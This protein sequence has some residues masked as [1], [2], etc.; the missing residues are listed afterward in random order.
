MNDILHPMSVKQNNQ[1]DRRTMLQ[2]ERK[3]EMQEFMAKQANIVNPRLRKIFKERNGGND[4]QP[5]NTYVPMLTN[6]K[7]NRQP[8]N[9]SP[10]TK[11]SRPTHNYSHEMNDTYQPP[12]HPQ[13]H[14]Q[15]PYFYPNQPLMYGDPR[16]S[17]PYFQPHQPYGVGGLPYP[18]MPNP[19]NNISQNGYP[20]MKPYDSRDLPQSSYGGSPIERNHIP[21]HHTRFEDNNNRPERYQNEQ[22]FGI[23]ERRHQPPE[24]NRRIPSKSEYAAA[25]EKQIAEKEAKKRLDR[26]LKQQTEPGM[27]FST[28]S[29]RSDKVSNVQPNTHHH[30]HSELTDRYSSRN[31]Q[32]QS[33]YLKE[34]D[35]QI[36]IKKEIRQKESYDYNHPPNSQSHEYP[37]STSPFSLPDIHH[38]RKQFPNE[39]AKIL[40]SDVFPQS[41]ST[42]T[43]QNHYSTLPPIQAQS[44]ISQSKYKGGDYQNFGEESFPPNQG[45]EIPTNFLRGAMQVKDMPQWQRE[46]MVI[47][48]QLKQKNQREVQNVLRQQIAEKEMLKQKQIEQQRKEDEIE[49]VRIEREQAL[50]KEKYRK[51]REEALKKEEEERKEKERLKKIK[52]QEEEKQTQNTHKVQTKRTKLSKPAISRTQSPVPIQTVSIPFRSDSPPIPTLLKKMKQDQ[53][54]NPIVEEQSKVEETIVPQIQPNVNNNTNSYISTT[55]RTETPQNINHGD[56]NFSKSAGNELL[57]QLEAIQRVNHKY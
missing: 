16:V 47:K 3:R 49:R 57:Q 38:T 50:L 34:L 22:N 33:Q 44:N 54:S 20:P 45:V 31:Q 21:Q 19:Y 15:Q 55:I 5:S 53:I 30:H 51:E 18:M 42:P 27:F 1:Q 7:S 24:S 39:R 46:E 40:H 43:F 8:D 23:G 32:S 2:Q 56:N 28:S 11:S 37:P 25:L 4:N 6:T 9:Y 36:R 52:E 26:K 35:D 13:Q 10:D 48:E 29:S 41:P 12:Y 17:L 14:V